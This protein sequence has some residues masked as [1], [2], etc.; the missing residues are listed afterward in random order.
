MRLACYLGFHCKSSIMSIKKKT[1]DPQTGRSLEE[2][3]ER[4][5]QS[6]LIEE[7][8]KE[9]VKE[10]KHGDPE[11][12]EQQRTGDTERSDRRL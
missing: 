9:V 11:T 7:K 8:D 2:D 6:G 10:D 12:K 3:I 4:L 5:Q 1:N